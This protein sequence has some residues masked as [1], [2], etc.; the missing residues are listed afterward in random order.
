[1][2]RLRVRLLLLIG[3]LI[4]FNSAERLINPINITAVTYSLVIAMVVVILAAPKFIKIPVWATMTISIGL[5]L[6]IKFWAGLP[7]RITEVVFSITEVCAV[8][9]TALLTHWV[10]QAIIDFEHAVDHITIGDLDRLNNNGSNGESVLY[11]EI[12]R[13]RNH[14]RPLA[15]LSISVDEKSVHYALDRIVKETQAAMARHYALSG[16]SKILCNALED[17]DVIVQC[18]NHFLV[19]LPETTSDNVPRLIERLRRKVQTDVGVDI[20]VGMATLPEDGLT[21]EGLIDK[22]NLAMVAEQEKFTAVEI[23]PIQIEK[24]KN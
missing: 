11:R 15:V 7:L 12:R 20:N 3:W 24:M 4:V 2:K 18:N 5:L 19:L 1:M 14:K 8:V 22:A 17:C 21:Y 6:V 23:S 13:A 10:N 9:A 16:V